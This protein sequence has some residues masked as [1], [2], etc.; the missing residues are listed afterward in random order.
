MTLSGWR[1][2]TWS[3]DSHLLWENTPRKI[4]SRPC[5]FEESRYQ[6]TQTLTLKHLL[7]FKS[8]G[9]NI[10]FYSD[11]HTQM[12]IHTQELRYSSSKMTQYKTRFL[13]CSSERH[14]E[15]GHSNLQFQVWQWYCDVGH[16][17]PGAKLHR[18]D[19]SRHEGG[20]F[21]ETAS[22]SQLSGWFC[23]PICFNVN[24]HDCICTV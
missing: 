4:F 3:P 23:R 18:G 7:I 21:L 24:A 20:R 9:P 22:Q 2:W 16:I 8:L 17:L 1:L 10:H 19:G 13:K 5:R 11:T 12:L 14:S 15:P 6:H